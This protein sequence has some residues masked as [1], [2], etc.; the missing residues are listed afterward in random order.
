MNTLKKPYLLL[1]I[2]SILILLGCIGLTAY[3]VFS[4]YQNVRLLKQAQR[5]FQRGD[6]NSL[7]IA[8]A[9]LK[10]I[11]AKDNDNESAYITLSEIAQK[12]KIYPEQ[13][14]YSYM[15]HRLNPLSKENKN[16]YIQ[17]LWHARYFD[18][19]ENFL[20][21]QTDLSPN[22]QHLLFYAA[23]RNGNINKYKS[24]FEQVKEK[25]NVAQ[26]TTL[27]FIDKNL[28]IDKKLIALS[29]IKEDKVTRQEVY[30]AEAENYLAIGNVTEAQKA[31]EKAYEENPYAFAMPLG[32]FYANFNS[33]GKALSIFERHITTYHDPMA[34]LQTAEIYCLL[35]KKSDIS[36][37]RTQYQSDLGNS[38]MLL[39]Y[40]FDAL[41]AFI[42]N[43]IAKLKEL[44]IP[45]RK[46]INTPLAQYMNFCVDLYD[47]NF[48]SAMENYT[49]LI[50]QPA[51]ANLQTKADNLLFN[52]LKSNLTKFNGKENQILPL[53][54]LL[55]SRKKDVFLAKF[56]LVIQKQTN[57]T[58]FSLIEDAL[59]NFSYDEGI[60]KLAI[61][62]Y[63]SH[64]LK[65]SKNLIKKY[66]ANF[67]Q[68]QKDMLRYELY[69]CLK[70]NNLNL[71]SK[72]FQKNFDANILPE[73]WNFASTTMR[74]NDLRFLSKDK[75][76]QPFCKALLLIKN[77]NKKT[78][79]QILEK[80]DA[81][82]N[83]DLL[84]FAA[85][86]L[87]ENGKNN[88]A[89]NKYAQFPD[90]SSYQLAVLL[91]KAELFAEIKN[92]DKALELA[93]KAYLLAP[94]LPEVQ[95]CYG[96]KLYQ[97]G[98][99]DKIPD[100]IKLKNNSKLKKRMEHLWV[101]GMEQK[102]KNCNLNIQKE[103][104]R[105]LCRQLLLVNKN[106]NVAIECLK[107]INKVLK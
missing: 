72:L 20:A 5:N 19:L 31:L 58:N 49:T 1:I 105:E 102:I 10:K 64:D 42:D 84:F 65:Q 106:N 78:A 94:D 104:A 55:Y 44:L 13:V 54:N 52:Y 24:N 95:F 59:K 60:L 3:V 91:N 96:D 86:T 41:S 7:L 76:Y 89:L 4:N 80:A 6:E 14:Y 99:L 69:L 68:K 8:D 34:A 92:L 90:N 53:A 81:K 100:V 18:R 30:A 33:L 15:A 103:K 43:D 97:N 66:K 39:C 88:A 83:L 29:K 67:T 40:Y 47:S 11:I 50:N 71:A 85:K 25:N 21:V 37:L 17:S 38:A 79:C 87:A 26:L 35:K 74:E 93:N 36:K 75:T 51:Y 32:R 46:R 22:F 107:K 62:Y 98:L 77:G 48:S 56:I 27:L 73:Y 70:E 45:L 9:Q 82:N 12:R 57:T 23:G 16:L 101:A 63:L 28:P 61:E 2:F